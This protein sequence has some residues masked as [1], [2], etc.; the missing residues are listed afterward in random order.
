[1]TQAVKTNGKAHDP[2]KI[3][4]RRESLDVSRIALAELTGLPTSRIWA[5]EQDG[6]E[7]SEE[8]ITIICAALDGVEKN[9]LPDHLRP[10][11]RAA[12]RTPTSRLKQVAALL[13][14]ALR[15][16]TAKEMR[17]VIEQA[18]AVIVGEPETQPE[19]TE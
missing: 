5:A 3:R 4:G 6:K 12:T 16:R 19:P 11:Q 17:A 14:E 9:G 10:K 15:T 18:Q 1:V 7:V 2:A 13:D 8:H